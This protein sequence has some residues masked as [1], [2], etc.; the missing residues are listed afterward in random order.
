MEPEDPF[1]EPDAGDVLLGEAPFDEAPL[2]ELSVEPLADPLEPEVPAE[3]LDDED[4][5]DEELPDERESVL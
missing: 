2:D 5:L 1:A 3:E 4:P